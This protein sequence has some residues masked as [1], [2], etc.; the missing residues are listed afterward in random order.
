[1]NYTRDQLITAL[2]A[3]YEFMCHDDFDPDVDM[4]PSEYLT[5]LQSLSIDELIDDITPPDNE[6]T[7][8]D[9]MTRYF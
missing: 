7:L 6:F 9:F 2:N 1:M 3:E 4:S 5:H 8:D